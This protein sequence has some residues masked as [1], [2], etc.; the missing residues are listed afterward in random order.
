VDNQQRILNRAYIMSNLD[1]IIKESIYYRTHSDEFDLYA[2]IPI[3]KIDDSILKA[4]V[5]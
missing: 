5:L 4:K 3:G 1:Y 2:P